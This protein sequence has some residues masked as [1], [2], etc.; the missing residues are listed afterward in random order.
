MAPADVLKFRKVSEI[1]RPS[2]RRY[3][4][5]EERYRRLRARHGTPRMLL[6]VAV[7]SVTVLLHCCECEVTQ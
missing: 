3:L 5:I 4:S 1:P 2:Y 6:S 7:L